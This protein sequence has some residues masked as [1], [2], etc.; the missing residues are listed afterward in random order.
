MPKG[1]DPAAY[2]FSR[3]NTKWKEIS[4]LRGSQ[5][6]P[7]DQFG[8]SVSIYD[9][10]AA[11]GATAEQHGPDRR[12]SAAVYLFEQF[13]ADWRQ[14]N[15]FGEG[16]TDP[17]TIGAAVAISAELMVASPNNSFVTS[18]L[19]IIVFTRRASSWHLDAELGD[20]DKTVA[21]AFGSSVAIVGETVAVGDPN[22]A[23]RVYM[24]QL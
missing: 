5:D 11:I 15:N 23:G 14:V 20:P 2:I 12:F 7:D 9:H 13:G 21:N 22:G 3:V 24:Y 4:E 1:W 18:G 19:P 16:T 17:P 10:T 8:I 6:V